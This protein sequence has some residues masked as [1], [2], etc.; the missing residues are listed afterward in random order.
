M[1]IPALQKNGELPPGEHPAIVD[2]VGAVFGSR[3]RRFILL[4]N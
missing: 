1:D 2:E 3:L 4:S